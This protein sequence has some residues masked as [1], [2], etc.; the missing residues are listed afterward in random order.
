MD[1]G[2]ARPTLPS[3]VTM[4]SLRRRVF[5]GLAII[6]GWA[7]TG[8]PAVDPK[9]SEGAAGRSNLFELTA[10]ETW[11]LDTP[12]GI[13][14][15]A[16]GLLFLP[17]GALLT[18]S[19]RE[20]MVA[21]IMFSPD[22]TAAR[23]EPQPQWFDSGQ[24]KRLAVSRPGRY[25]S[26]GLGID[27]EGRVYLCEESRRWILRCD[28]KTHAVER[29]EID[30]SPVSRFFS[31]DDNASFE[32]VAVGGDRLYVAN[33][34][35]VGRIIVVDLATL[36][37]IDDWQASPI[38]VS[39]HDIHYSD[40][41]WREGRLWVLCRES[42]CVLEVDPGTHKTLAQYNYGRIEKSRQ[43]AY[44]SF[45]PFGITEGLAVDAQNIWLVT[46]NNGTGRVAA[47]SD[48]RPTLWRCP[49]PG[50]LER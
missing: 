16:S 25:D 32:G 30:W 11:R 49:R 50:R 44:R 21:R 39:A 26:E 43:N 47:P 48:T 37:V 5:L 41:S 22:R 10:V 34:R 35:S 28:P 19:D 36:K 13:R 3:G 45:F 42:W 9:A 17:D 1:N 18:V 14:Y 23:L 31:S 12:G 6:L 2:L 24:L 4:H 40:L 46:D 38:G 33:E 20:G 7:A 15:D 27:A 8:S 29:L